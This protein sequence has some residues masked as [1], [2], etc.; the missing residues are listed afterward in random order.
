MFPPNS[1]HNPPALVVPITDFTS[2]IIGAVLELNEILVLVAFPTIPPTQELLSLLVVTFILP[3]KW[4]FSK[5]E[6]VESATIPPTY[7]FGL[8]NEPP[9]VNEIFPSTYRF[10]I[11][12]S[13]QEANNPKYGVV[14]IG[15]VVSLILN[16]IVCPPPSNIPVKLLIGV[17]FP[18]ISI[19]SVRIKRSLRFGCPID[20]SSCWELI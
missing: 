20:A 1:P 6:F 2:A 11:V 8:K 15:P 12:A 5:V 16:V 18:V 10:L 17:Q 19:S 3:E 9:V 4:T 14:G 7:T 13:V